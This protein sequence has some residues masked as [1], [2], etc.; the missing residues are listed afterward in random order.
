MR[1]DASLR[2][3]LDALDAAVLFVDLNSP[4]ARDFKAVAGSRTT[5]WVQQSSGKNVYVSE[6]PATATGVVSVVTGLRA[7]VK[8]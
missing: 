6:A 4:A 5:I 1:A 7:G 2:P 3:A 8:P